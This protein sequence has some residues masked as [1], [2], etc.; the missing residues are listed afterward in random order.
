[1]CNTAA[2]ET[3]VSQYAHTNHDVTSTYHLVREGSASYPNTQFVPSQSQAPERRS[4]KDLEL[5]ARVNVC[6]RNVSPNVPQRDTLVVLS[7][8]RRSAAWVRPACDVGKGHVARCCSGS[9]DP[10]RDSTNCH[11]TSTSRALRSKRARLWRCNRLA[12]KSHI[13]FRDTPVPL[14]ARIPP[15]P[16]LTCRGQRRRPYFAAFSSGER[17]SRASLLAWVVSCMLV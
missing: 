1:M 14:L 16:R 3:E 4:A 11:R 8:A 9:T 10:R 13:Q 15:R 12:G 7:R 17:G 6:V 2:V 5:R